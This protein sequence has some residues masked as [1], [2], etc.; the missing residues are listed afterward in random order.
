[1]LIGDK[2]RQSEVD[3]ATLTRLGY[4]VYCAHD[5]TTANSILDHH[6]SVVAAV[7]P[8]E[9]RTY[10]H[11]CGV[12]KQLAA[13]RGLPVLCLLD[14]SVEPALEAIADLPHHVLVMRNIPLP[15]MDATISN[16]VS[17]FSELARYRLLVERQTDLVVQIDGQGRFEFVS[18]SYCKTFGKEEKDLLGGSFMPLVHP[19]DRQSTAEAMA[20]LRRP[21]YRA[22]VEQRAMTADGWRHFGWSDSTVLDPHGHVAAI[23]GV[24]RDITKQKLAEDLLRESE[25]RFR[26][27]LE[28]LPLGVFLH[29]LDGRLLLINARACK[30]TGYSR[31]ELVT[32][33][34]GDIDPE[35]VTR[36]DRTRIWEHLNE[37][38]TTNFAAVHREKSGK[39]H[40]VGVHLTAITL[41]GEPA[42]L[43]VAENLTEKQEQET[44]YRDTISR[45]S[46]GYWL[47]DAKGQIVD[48]NPAAARMLGYS[49][50]E[51]TRM[52]VWDIDAAEDKTDARARIQTILTLG[53][54][55]FETRHQKRDGSIIDVEVDTSS[56]GG[57]SSLFVTLVR[58][59]TARK[60]REAA[61]VRRLNALTR[62]VTDKT[63][64]SFEALF[65]IDAIQR[66]QDQFAD[67]TGVASIIATP[68]GVPITTSSRFCRLC[69][70]L[71]RGTPK[72]EAN[73][74]RS[75]ACL[76]RPGANGPQIQPCLSAGL[77]DA[78]TAITI[79]GTHVANWLIGQVRDAGHSF[80]S[81]RA[82][83]REIGAD[84]DEVEAAFK[85]VPIMSRNR[86]E[87]VANLLYIVATQLSELAYSNLQLAKGV[88]HKN[89]LMAELNH[90]VK[91]NLAT[92]L[93]LL[94]LKKAALGHEVDLSDLQSRITTI[95]SVHE[96]LSRNEGDLEVDLKSYIPDLVHGILSGAGIGPIAVYIDIPSVRLP[97]KE[98]TSLG[99]VVNEITTN[100]LKHGFKGE[101]EHSY[102]VRMTPSDDRKHLVLR[103]SNSGTPIA[104]DL[105]TKDSQTLGLAL[106]QGLIAGLGGTVSIERD[107]VTTVVVLF[108]WDSSHS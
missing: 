59:V 34:V 81:I 108:P 10:D 60:Q 102:R 58:D 91:N 77:W 100:A 17:L 5:L 38:R 52:Q 56:L 74:I 63:P 15:L 64:V 42:I 8:V 95:Q 23:V 76:A 43:A 11:I 48:A 54:G 66:L 86:F 4:Q 45:M 98:A 73:C 27:V 99:L 83:A 36:E 87:K 93:S 101:Q 97:A 29:D 79:G 85:E 26:S 24:G 51:L 41:D 103:L 78:G 20:N 12:V 44:T 55:R 6:R 53:H 32:M 49:I 82:Y 28:H 18:P 88:N 71:V 31:D 14:A 30:D 46:D 62:P 37:T 75:D 57:D 65:D 61:T 104:G 47:V 16:A 22:Y 67:A 33:S 72:G 70:D 19:D 96:L 2:T 84:E 13:D 21:P 7:A 40:P 106:V 92:V 50:A 105:I 107:P 89:K 35:S 68:T 9:R 90:R 1:M 94:S 80:E 3:R 39:T 25:N 69:R